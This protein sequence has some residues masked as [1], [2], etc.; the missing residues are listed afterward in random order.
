MTTIFRRGRLAA[1]P[2][3]ALSVSVLSLAVAILLAVPAFAADEA[4]TAPAIRFDPA[5]VEPGT[6]LHY[7]KSNRDGSQPW[8]VAVYSVAPTRVEVV[9]Y[10]KGGED[11]VVVEV[12]LD[13]VRGHMAHAFQTNLTAADSR[14][15]MAARVAADG[16]TVGVKLGNGQALELP[17]AG[18]PFHFYGFDFLGIGW[19]L[20]HLVDP[21]QSFDVTM[22][23]P[24]RPS[25]RDDVPIVLT[26]ARFEPAGEEMLHGKKCRKYLLKGPFFAGF[27]GRLWADFESGRLEKVESSLRT[28][29]DWDQDFLLEL[30]KSEQLD[31]F[32]WEARKAAMR[33]ELAKGNP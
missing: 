28:S 3:S 12:D 20:P 32:E 7:V 22:V 23:D 26:T 6:L 18:L 10:K 29:T 13:P 27:E 30:Q 24:N 16:R 21:G 11:M 5:R 33:A 17:L 4:A 14:A 25:G 19:L 15:T 31:D 8:Q 2:L 1:L 9:K